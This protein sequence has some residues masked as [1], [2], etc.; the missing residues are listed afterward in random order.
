MADQKEKD[1]SKE[2]SRQIAVCKTDKSLLELC[3]NLKP[4]SRLFP[5][6]IHASGEK[7]EN[8]ERS[9]IRLNMLDYS[10]GTGEKAV[11][12]RANISP[13]EARYIYS[14]LTSHLFDFNFSQEKIF[15]EPENGFSTVTKLQIGRYDTDSQGKKRNYPWY[16]EIQNG[17][18]VAATNS[19]GGRYC[20]KGS[21]VCERA[22][23]QFFSDRD[24]FVLFSRAVSYITAFELEYAFR[25]N[26]IGNFG[27]LY[28]MLS[29]EI[30]KVLNGQN[31]IM[32]KIIPFPDR[33]KEA[34]KK[35]G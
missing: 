30:G 23:K 33:Q 18:G 25:Q 20:K 4:A 26:R 21:Y 12:A 27:S 35:T 5:A 29:G 1:W 19:N 8:G 16:V 9:L 7:T 17:K 31:E 6:H 10:K 14:A 3:E 11:S 34:E 2:V 24:M 28:R 22:V 13:D 32:C 15:G